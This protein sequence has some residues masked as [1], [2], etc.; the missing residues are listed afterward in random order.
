[1]PISHAPVVNVGYTV[2]SHPLRIVSSW[3]A[4]VR[5]SKQILSL[6][7][8]VS[9]ARLT[10]VCV[11]S[12]LLIFWFPY[13]LIFY[14]KM[15]TETVNALVFDYLNSLDQKLAVMFQNKTKAVSNHSFIFSLLC[16]GN[17]VCFISR[18]CYSHDVIVAIIP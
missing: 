2:F 3:F 8:A 14:F 9:F 4:G 6:F 5:R 7:H 1:M 12:L 15:S 18:C 11:N 16:F 17:H 10:R 13:L